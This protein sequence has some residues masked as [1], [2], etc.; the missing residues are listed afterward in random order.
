MCISPSGMPYAFRSI[1]ISAV[2]S[3]N[4]DETLSGYAQRIWELVNEERAKENLNPVTFNPELNRVANIRAMEIIQNSGH[5]RPDGSSWSTVFSE[6]HISVGTCGENIISMSGISDIAGTAMSAWMGSQI[7]HDNIMNGNYNHIGVGVV[8]DGDTCYLVQ[9]LASEAV[10][11]DISGNIF[12]IGGTGNTPSYNPDNR[13]WN[14]ALENI[15]ET[16]IGNGITKIGRYVFY[17]MNNLKSV[18]L[19]ESVK[20][21]DIYAFNECSS[22]EEVIFM[23]PECEIEGSNETIPSGAVICGYENSTA[24]TFAEQYGYNFKVLENIF[25]FGDVNGD[26]K[27]N[28]VD[29]SVISVEY[30][31]LSTDGISG[32]TDEQNKAGDADGDGKI[33][34]IDASYIASY[35]AYLSTGGTETDMQ[36]WIDSSE[37]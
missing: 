5:T 21:I 25:V 36:K 34:A 31:L 23:N 1:D 37:F 26:R 9:V 15:T 35:Y 24:Q 20:K 6:N 13:P 19:P 11:W 27:V 28:A 4:D 2:V 18:T 30:A 8:Q 12:I 29:A 33:S 7:H 16:V 3:A 10:S 14:D 32:F 17:G 22:L